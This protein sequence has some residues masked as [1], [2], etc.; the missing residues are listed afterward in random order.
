MLG[1]YHA[2]ALAFHSSSVRSWI[3]LNQYPSMQTDREHLQAQKNFRFKMHR[4]Y[5]PHTRQASLSAQFWCECDTTVLALE[6][7]SWISNLASGLSVSYT[8][9]CNY[10][11]YFLLFKRFFRFSFYLLSFC[12]FCMHFIIP[13]IFCTKIFI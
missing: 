11:Y 6:S 4:H 7:L 5:R 10:Y 1:K 3:R 8:C 12:F 13:L 9:K 2:N